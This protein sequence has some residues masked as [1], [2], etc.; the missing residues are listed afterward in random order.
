[1]SG[2]VTTSAIV[3]ETQEPTHAK[4]VVDKPLPRRL[5]NILS[6]NDFEPAARRYLPHSVFTFVQSGVE[7]EITLRDNR[8]AFPDYHLIRRDL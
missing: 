2:D 6:L 3:A 8:A 7:V 1:M 5:R 4:R